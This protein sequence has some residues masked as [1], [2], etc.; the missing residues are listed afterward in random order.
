[1]L[2]E[3]EEEREV[4]NRKGEEEDPVQEIVES[5]EEVVEEEGF[6]MFEQKKILEMRRV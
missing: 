1:M 4:E 2:R 6:M 5:W 3:K